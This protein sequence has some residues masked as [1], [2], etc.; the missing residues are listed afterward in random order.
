LNTPKKPGTDLAALKARLAKKSKDGEE[1]AAPAAAEAAPVEHVPA[2]AAPIDHGHAPEQHYDPPAAFDA[3]PA[4]SPAAEVRHAAPAAPSFSAPATD[5]PFGGPSN[6]SYDP[7]PDLGGDVVPGR[8]NV[9][10]IAFAGGIFLVIGLGA[11]WLGHKII[12]GGER[13]DAAKAKGDEMYEEVKKVSDARK[14]LALKWEELKPQVAMDPAA[15]SQAIVALMGETF[16]KSPN[17]DALFGWQLAAIHSSGIKKVFEL[18]EKTTRVRIELAALAGFLQ[19]NA[20]TLKGTGG[21]VSFGVKFGADGSAQLVAL[22]GALCGEN[23]TDT[24]AL[25]NCEDP[26]KAI[27]FKV[28]ESLGGEEKTLAKGTGADQVVFLPPTGNVFN[29]AIGLE[30][31]KNAAN[32][33]DFMMKRIQETVD[34]MDK[35]EKTALKAL[36]NYASN[37]NVDGSNEQ[38]DPGE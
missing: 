10:V 25:K 3:A 28:Q 33:R 27:A 20:A 6:A 22:T 32:V 29:Y 26:S 11:G 37:P 38:P 34:E 23:L 31:A 21:P 14:G 4:F 17:L 13:L 7:G 19:E 2:A 12:S 18:Y 5:D 24:A 35:A 30:P 15:G 8:S 16:E 1:A 36:E 9:G